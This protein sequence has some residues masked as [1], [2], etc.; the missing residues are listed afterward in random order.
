MSNG[1]YKYILQLAATYNLN[2]DLKFAVYGTKMHENGT[3]CSVELFALWNFLVRKQGSVPGVDFFA[4]RG[5]MVSFNIVL[6]LQPDA[7]KIGKFY[8]EYHFSSRVAPSQLR[9]P[10]GMKSDM[11]GKIFRFYPSKGL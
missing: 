5:H 10:R 7:D 11:R 3:F 2:K 8:P 6:I 9:K 4:K 1:L